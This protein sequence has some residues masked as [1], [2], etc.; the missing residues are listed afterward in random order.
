MMGIGSDF[1]VHSKFPSLAEGLFEE[2]R[3]CS[4][5]GSDFLSELADGYSRWLGFDLHG[6]SLVF[7]AVTDEKRTSG[8]VASLSEVN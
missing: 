5:I 2:E 7:E 1:F 6:H 3:N 4:E 8:V